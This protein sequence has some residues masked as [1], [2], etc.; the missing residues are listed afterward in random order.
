MKSFGA[1]FLRPDAL[2]GVKHMRV[3]GYLYNVFYPQYIF[4]NLTMQFYW[5]LCTI[6]CIVY[7]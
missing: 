3:I 6:H 4:Y 2:P 7:H 1:E 5:F